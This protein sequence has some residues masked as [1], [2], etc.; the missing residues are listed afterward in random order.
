MIISAAAKEVVP[1]ETEILVQKGNSIVRVASGAN[2]AIVYVQADGGGDSGGD[3][4]QAGGYASSESTLQIRGGDFGSTVFV[5]VTYTMEVNTLKGKDDLEGN[6]TVNIESLVNIADL[7]DQEVI[8]WEADL[9]LYTT[10]AQT[11]EADD[12]EEVVETIALLSGHDY[13]LSLEVTAEARAIGKNLAR[14]EAE[15]L[16]EPCV[17]INTEQAGYENFSMKRITPNGLSFTNSDGGRIP[18]GIPYKHKCENDGPNAIIIAP[19]IDLVIGIG[20][21]G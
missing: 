15:A 11:Q 10:G 17:S 3:V 5:D 2:R 20:V 7:S 16:I 19:I 9:D 8:I 12:A 21:R 14:G 1:Y 13:V 18:Y 4:N 6:A